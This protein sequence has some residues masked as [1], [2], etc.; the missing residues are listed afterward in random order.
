MINKYLFLN[1]LLSLVIFSS[2]N[3]SIID[4]KQLQGC[5]IT[6]ISFD[7]K[8]DQF[9][10]NIMLSLKDGEGIISELGLREQN[11]SKFTYQL[12]G[13]KMMFNDPGAFFEILE[14]SDDRLKINLF[15]GDTM[16]LT[17]IDAP[18]MEL[19]KL[20]ELVNHSFKLKVENENTEKIIHFTPDEALVLSDD[21][22]ADK[23]DFVYFSFGRANYRLQSIEDVISLEVLGID[24]K[25]GFPFMGVLTM[26][27]ENFVLL[28]Y[29]D[30]G[31]KKS[32]LS[33]LKNTSTQSDQ[34]YGRWR[35][36]GGSRLETF[37]FMENGTVLHTKNDSK[38]N[39]QWTTDNSGYLIKMTDDGG[40][41]SYGVKD[42]GKSEYRIGY[43]FQRGKFSDLLKTGQ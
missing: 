6:E 13:N 21:L 33:K 22:L 8:S 1:T 30:Q 2:C 15:E 42:F 10:T 32:Y 5:W 37:E 40:N 16:Q 34:L 35:L 9:S 4:S 24:Q 36:W 26:E 27:D 39:M 17:R 43:E 11:V 14:C 18:Y 38:T 23:D 12:S 3:N 25:I 41:I 31:I 28:T 20:S 29:T 19:E 7:Q